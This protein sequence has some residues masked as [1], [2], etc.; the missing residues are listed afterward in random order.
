MC[1]TMAGLRSI[2]STA[3][4]GSTARASSDVAAPRPH[5]MSSTRS[6]CSRLQGLDEALGGRGEER[7]AALV[8][9][10]GDGL[11]GGAHPRDGVRCG[12]AHRP[13]MA[14][15]GLPTDRSSVGGQ[16]AQHAAQRLGD[17]LG[18]LAVHPVADTVDDD[19]SGPR[20]QGAHLPRCRRP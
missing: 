3:P 7:H 8:V 2:A 17:H 6:P 15:R 5:P 14:G 1:S 13:S 12:S 4:A 20:E 18:G 16:Q 11:E 10:V 19:R 9:V